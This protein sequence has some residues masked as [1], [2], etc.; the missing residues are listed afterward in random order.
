[1][2]TTP[3]PAAAK[4]PL[5]DRAGYPADR[6]LELARTLLAETTPAGAFATALDG[7]IELSGAERGLIAVFDDAGRARFEAARNLAREDL[8][9]PEFEVSRTIIDRVRATGEPVWEANALDDPGLGKRQSVLRLKILSVICLPIRR[10]EEAFGAVYLDNRSA[11][12]VFTR[13]TAELSA[14]FAELISLAAWGALERER[15]ARRVESL[16]R[17]LDRRRG[18]GR[19]V[20]QDPRMLAAL[21]LAGRVAAARAPVLLTGESG[22]GK[23]LV[24]RAIHAES[25]VGGE[26][27]SVNCGA[28]PDELFEAE[29]FGSRRGAYTGA[30]RDVPGWFERA[31]GGTLFLDEIGEVTPGCQA[32]LLRVLETGEYS[33]LGETRLRRSDARVVAATN[34]SLRAETGAGRFREDLYYRLAVVEVRLPALR[35]RP[36]DVPLLAHHLLAS[37]NARHGRE[38]R[39]SRRAERRLLEHP[40]PGNVR[41]LKNVLERAVLVARG[42][43]IRL[44]DL[45]VSLHEP[46]VSAAGEPEGLGF[47]E[48][49]HRALEAFERGY[50]ARCLRSTE[51]NVSAA[52][53]LAGIDY[54]NFHTKMTGYGIDRR[55]FRAG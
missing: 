16:R 23:E 33:P 22:T 55:S 41:E 46:A 36:G 7:L 28:L 18:F 24:A 32:K 12:G 10:G 29:L 50:L 5:L 31:R 45:P 4:P 34:R 19:I 54:K 37:L 8:E 3:R 15:L 44:A 43:E 39:L 1:M 21:E 40:W 2:A 42:P 48:A 25:G 47:R 13:E 26:L 6:L 11:R 9:A 30:V 49:K 35:E 51:G 17:E 27:V 14:R 38:L 20:T 53:R 52:A